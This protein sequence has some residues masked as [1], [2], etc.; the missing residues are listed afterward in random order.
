MLP[1]PHLTATSTTWPAEHSDPA[2]GAGTRFGRLVDGLCPSAAATA[3]TTALGW[4]DR[5]VSL[6][7]VL[8]TE[9]CRLS[10]RWRRA[11]PGPRTYCAVP[12]ARHARVGWERPRSPVVALVDPSGWAAYGRGRQFRP[13]WPT[14]SCAGRLAG[15]TG[16]AV[17]DRFAEAAADR[18]CRA[19]GT[20]DRARSA[21]LDTCGRPRRPSSMS[22]V[23]VA[24]GRPGPGGTPSCWLAA[25][26][27]GL[28]IGTRSVVFARR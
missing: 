10:M 8:T 2:G 16:R 11:T 13:R 9:I 18:T 21:D 15:A 4:L 25:K 19:H 12:A 6:E 14:C 26:Q 3:I 7:P 27:R 1:V 5:V 20:G 28:V 23:R 22:T 24:V 17:G